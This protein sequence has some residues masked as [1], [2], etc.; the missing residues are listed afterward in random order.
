MRPSKYEYYI[1]FAKTAMLRST[2]LKRNYGA[3]I[4]KDDR[5]ISTGYNGAPRGIKNCTDIGTCP[6][7]YVPSNTVYTSCR[8][9][10]AEAN[11]IIHA[12]Y[13]DMI[14]ATLFLYGQDAQTGEQLAD[15]QPCPMCRRMII[16]A[17]IKTVVCLAPTSIDGYVIYETADWIK[18]DNEAVRQHQLESI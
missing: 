12:N 18:D 11:A 4:I 9:V 5:V 10:H 16:N 8:S 13:N 3:V 15:V 17:Q 7:L 1:E 2:C 6:R 14:G